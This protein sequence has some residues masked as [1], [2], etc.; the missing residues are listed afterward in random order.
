MKSFARKIVLTA[1][2]FLVCFTVPSEAQV[3]VQSVA[4]VGFTVS[5]MDRS[6]AFYR[7]VLTFTPLSDVEV[8]GP[9][10]DQFWGLFGVRAR[11][12][13]LQLG[14]QELVLTEFL[15]PP[16][17]RP[18]PMPSYSHDLWFQHCAIV[19]RD[20]EAAWAQLRKHHVRQVSPRP[21]T[22]PRSNVAAAGIKAMKFRDPDGHNL[23]LL[24]FPD[25]KGHPRW[26]R[27]GTDL[28]LGIDHT[29]MTVRS[30]ENSTKFYRDLLG[31]TVAGGTLNMGATQQYLDSLPGART[32]VTG[33]A[34]KLNPPS[35][36]FL[37]YELPTAGRPFPIDSHPTD[38]WHWQ[39]T[40]VVS[41]VE[42]AASA[43]RDGA[44]FVSSGVVTLPD[45]SVGFGKG[46][47]VRDPDGHVMQVVSP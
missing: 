18:I 39:T 9:E 31:M 14:E 13:R 41:D 12:V 17:L 4:S 6:I 28:F 19:V 15:S 5:D 42:A 24:W 11:V 33:L 20:M 32:R 23:E 47:L 22:I 10:Y 37:E 45:K 30:T 40:L 7:D 36:E 8:D 27:G 38:L 34:P 26:Q 29:A 16:D 35:L 43:L 21:Q 46:F 1:L 25:G 2:P 44:Q 3:A